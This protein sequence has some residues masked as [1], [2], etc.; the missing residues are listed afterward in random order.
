V[1]VTVRASGYIQSAYYYANDEHGAQYPECRT[2]AAPILSSGY[3]IHSGLSGSMHD[4]CLLFKADIDILGTQN[5]IA[6]HTIAPVVESYPWSH[7][8]TRSSMK[9]ERSYIASEDESMINWSHNAQTMLMVVNTD[10]PNAFGEPRGY[11]IQPGRGGGMHLTIKNSSNLLNAQNFATHQ[12]YV[13]QHKD[14][15]PHASHA[16]NNYDVTDPVIDFAAFFNGEGLHQEDVVLWFNLG[17]HHVPHTGDLPNTVFSTAQGSML[18]MPHNYLL[19]DPSRDSRQTV[20]IDY[21]DEQGVEIIKT[22]DAELANGSV[23]LVRV[24]RYCLPVEQCR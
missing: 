10:K 21:D 23:N 5:S 22:F 7:G 6:N 20:R 11:R 12:L 13:T 9:L 8:A 18:I 15:E 24:P 19:H 1:E 17:M 16:L 14:S 2:S 3:K 4:H